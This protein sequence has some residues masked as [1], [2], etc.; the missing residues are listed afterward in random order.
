[1]KTH[2]VGTELFHPERRTDG[3][4]D[5]GAAGQT[6]RHEKAKRS[7]SQFSESAKNFQN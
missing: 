6:E 7:F 5:G 3:G 2:S 4:R 1:M